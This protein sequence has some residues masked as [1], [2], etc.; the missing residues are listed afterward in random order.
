MTPFCGYNMADYFSHWFEM[1]DKLGSKAP[2]IFYAN[3]FRKDQNGEFLWPGFGENSRVLKWMCERVEG[4]AKA[5]ATPIGYLPA[6][7]ALDLNGLTLPRENIS[8][9][10]RIDRNAWNQ[11]EI[12]SI[13]AY[14]QLFGANLPERLK[15]QLA[16]LK[17][18]LS[19]F[20]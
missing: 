11:M 10:L 17:S 15:N 14:F 12:P 6:E 3:W 7:D 4:K 13:E 9:L 2:A 8:E 19:N 16:I 5:K 20:P 18:E 1:G